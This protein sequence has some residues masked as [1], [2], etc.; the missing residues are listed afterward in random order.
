MGLHLRNL[1]RAKSTRRS[2]S[3]TLSN[4]NGCVLESR[5]Y[6]RLILRKPYIL[7]VD[8]VIFVKVNGPIREFM[9]F[10][11]LGVVKLAVFFIKKSRLLIV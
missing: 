4:S 2:G 11:D 1:K 5:P 3:R 6:N 10:Q 8:M 7:T 9:G